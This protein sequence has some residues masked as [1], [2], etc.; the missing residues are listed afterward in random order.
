MNLIFPTFWNIINIY[1]DTF[2]DTK[3][4]LSKA[5]NSAFAV[6]IWYIFHMCKNKK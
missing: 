5:E 6:G 1:R 2:V 4:T 3:M